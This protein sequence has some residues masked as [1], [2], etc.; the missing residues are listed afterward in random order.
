MTLVAGVAAGA[1]DPIGVQRRQATRSELEQ[2]VAAT[3]RAMAA[4]P[5]ERARERL[6][7]QATAVRQR[8]TNGDFTPGNRILIT[9]LGDSSLSDTFTVRTDQRLQLPNLPDISLRGVLDSELSTHLEKE[10]GKYIRNPDVNA[11][12]LVRLT[13]TGSA[14]R[15]GFYTV[16]FDM[17]VTDV[18][19]LA[20]G[21]TQTSKL[22][23]TIVRRSGRTI[24]DRKQFAE[25]LRMGKTVG[26]VS[27]IDGDEIYVPSSTPTNVF[28]RV[29]TVAGPVLTL[30]VLVTRRF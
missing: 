16:P 28:T 17:A 2:T 13:V 6:S 30:I 11:T 1:Q 21:P 10:I 27:I 22:D 23:E 20:G 3:E 24:L 29:M 15:P 18:V 14:G 5:D 9:V 12:G 4:T 26:D 19:T 7:T 8:L 25:M